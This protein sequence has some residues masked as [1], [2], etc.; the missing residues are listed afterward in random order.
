MRFFIISFCGN[1]LVSLHYKVFVFL[2]TVDV[3]TNHW[4][5]FAY[6]I[7]AD[8]HQFAEFLVLLTFSSNIS[9]FVCFQTVPSKMNHFSTIV[10]FNFCHI[11]LAFSFP[12]LFRFLCLF[13]VGFVLGVLFFLSFLVNTIS[14]F[15]CNLSTVATSSFELFFC[16]FS[17]AGL[18]NSA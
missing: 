7:I 13:F 3:C 6:V 15:V 10:E 9:V 2:I 17:L 5:L 4:T 18:A 8:I 11:G 16:P 14:C 12:I 1:A